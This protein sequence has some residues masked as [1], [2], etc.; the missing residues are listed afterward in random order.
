MY[1]PFLFSTSEQD[2]H[3]VLLRRKETEVFP[4]HWHEEVE[5]GYISA[6]C[7]IYRIDGENLEIIQCGTHYRQK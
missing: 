1:T 5:I 2:L 4:M 7:G 3:F 6:G